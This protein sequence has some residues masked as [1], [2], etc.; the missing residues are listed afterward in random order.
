MLRAMF[1]PRL[2]ERCSHSRLRS[3]LWVWPYVLAVARSTGL[4]CGSGLDRE[5]SERQPRCYSELRSHS[6]SRPLPRVHGAAIRGCDRCH[7]YGRTSWRLR[8]LPASS[9]GAVLTANDP[10]VN[11]TATASCVAIRGQ[12]RS[13]GCAAQPIAVAIAVMGMAVRLGRCAIHRPRLWER[14]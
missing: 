12:D 9:V 3:L 1:R 10:N 14:S 11:H 5:R 7:G 6:R 2:W 8:Y 4:V 13:H